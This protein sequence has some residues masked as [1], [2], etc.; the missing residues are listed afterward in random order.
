MGARRALQV[1][2]RRA[3]RDTYYLFYNAKDREQDWIEQIGVA[4]SS[5]LRTWTRHPGNPVL[6]IGP[7][8]AF[9]DRFAS[10]PCVFRAGDVWVMFTYGLSSDGHARD[11]VAFSRD[12]VRWTKADEVLVDVGP[13]G[14][15]DSRYAHKP[16]VFFRGGTLYHFYCAVAPSPGGRMGEIETGEVRGI[17]LATSRPAG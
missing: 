4:T 10:E 13:P 15:I 17:A 16:S 8:R 3:R 9:D 1:V 12:L 7:P 11:G 6:P 2:P 14:S 5:D